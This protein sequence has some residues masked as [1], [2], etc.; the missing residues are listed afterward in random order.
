MVNRL[1]AALLVSVA[2]TVAATA[3][4][5]NDFRRHSEETGCGTELFVHDL[6]SVGALASVRTV[7]WGFSISVG[8]RNGYRDYR[9]GRG[10]YGYHGYRIERRQNFYGPSRNFYDSDPSYFYYE[11]R[12]REG[13]WHHHDPG[14]RYRSQDGFYRHPLPYGRGYGRHHH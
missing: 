10:Y 8:H 12:Y 5:A 1:L 6:D 11:K 3:A 2:L 4:A 13:D 7:A 9:H 14:G